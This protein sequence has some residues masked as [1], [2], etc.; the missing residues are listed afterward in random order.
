M[1]GESSVRGSRFLAEGESC[2]GRASRQRGEEQRLE[3]VLN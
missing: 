2:N 3:V 1:A